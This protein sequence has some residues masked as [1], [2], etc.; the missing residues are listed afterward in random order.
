MGVQ[1]DP[2]SDDFTLKSCFDVGLPSREEWIG[3]LVANAAK[4]MALETA[5]EEIKEKWALVRLE[6]GVHKEIYYKLVRDC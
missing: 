1:F 6:I 2:A 3:E 5:L 4:E